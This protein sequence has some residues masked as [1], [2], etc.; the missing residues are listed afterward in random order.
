MEFKIHGAAVLLP[1]CRF[2][3]AIGG[4]AG[5]NR[6]RSLVRWARLAFVFTQPVKRRL[7]RESPDYAT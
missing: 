7:D 4:I 5:E 3:S 1:A 2:A 6:R